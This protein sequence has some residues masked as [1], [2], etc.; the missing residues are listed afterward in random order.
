[1]LFSHVLGD[2]GGGNF[3]GEHSGNYEFLVCGNP[4]IRNVQIYD[5]SC[6]PIVLFQFYNQ[7]IV[8][9]QTKDEYYSNR[10][11]AYIKLESYIGES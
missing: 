6:F 7:A 9:D 11:Q 3:V 5:T 10:A 8:E 2:E 4:I 1:M